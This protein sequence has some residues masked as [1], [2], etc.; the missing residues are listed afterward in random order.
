MNLKKIQNTENIKV[1]REIGHV[2]YVIL[3]QS[4]EQINNIRNMFLNLFPEICFDKIVYDR[5]RT[6]M[7][8]I[9]LMLDKNDKRKNHGMTRGYRIEKGFVLKDTKGKEEYEPIRWAELG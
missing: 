4:E 9:I 1:N 6:P 5:L 2:D 3:C 7:G 8:E